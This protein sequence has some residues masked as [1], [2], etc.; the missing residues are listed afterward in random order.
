MTGLNVETDHILE[1]ACLITDSSLKTL[2]E[3]PDIIIHQPDSV[4]QS[5]NAWCKKHHVEVS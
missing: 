5:M 1:I 3:G 4:L 2:I